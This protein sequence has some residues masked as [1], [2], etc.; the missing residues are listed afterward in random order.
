[1]LN[2]DFKDM[3]SCLR[4]EKVK[5]IVVGAYALAAHGF[6]RATGDI[7]IWVRSDRANAQKVMRALV[8]F[9]APISDISEDDFTVPERVLQIGVEPSRVDL[10]TGVDAVEF[11]EAWEEKISVT[12]DELEIHVL[13]KRH[14]LRNKLATGRDKDQGDIFWLEKN[15]NTEN[16]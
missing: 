6:P 2:P 8:K 5:F 12:I 16:L 4:D 10:L 13:S 1:M 14:L 9:G 15:Q 11:D 3:L 7:D